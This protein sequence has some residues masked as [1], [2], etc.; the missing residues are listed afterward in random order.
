MAISTSSAILTRPHFATRLLAKS[1]SPSRS[2][3]ATSRGLRREG[4]ESL[5][6]ETL[7]VLFPRVLPPN[8]GSA[9]GAASRSPPESLLSGRTR[10]GA[11]SQPD[12]D[13]ASAR[14]RSAPT[15]LGRLSGTRTRAFGPHGARLELPVR[16][17]VRSEPSPAP[18]RPRSALA[19]PLPFLR[20]PCETSRTSLFLN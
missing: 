8:G 2:A 7:L 19:S 4:L 18:S 9:G 20:F 15:R 14:C 12:A 1:R 13:P 16:Q 3:K 10:L 6:G 17:P 5:A 11:E